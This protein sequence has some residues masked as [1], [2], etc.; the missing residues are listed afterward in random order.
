M[1]HGCVVA[2]LVFWRPWYLMLDVETLL[3]ALDELF[4][5]LAENMGETSEKS[6]M[7]HFS[8]DDC[9]RVESTHRQLVREAY[10]KPM[11]LEI[12]H[13]QIFVHTRNALLGDNDRPY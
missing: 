3:L 13:L 7:F 11:S 8:L 2:F 1:S 5:S 10:P 9:P 6:L 12:F 4:E